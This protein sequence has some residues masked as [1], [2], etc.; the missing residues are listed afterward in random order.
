MS[1]RRL[2]V[3]PYRPSANQPGRIARLPYSS[4]SDFSRVR[5]AV[6]LGAAALTVALHGVLI[7]PLLWGTGAVDPKRNLFGEGDSAD[8]QA[9]DGSRMQVVLLDAAQA[10]AEDSSNIRTLSLADPLVPLREAPKI[11]EPKFFRSDDPPAL[12]ASQLSANVNASGGADGAELFGRY[13]GQITARIDRAWRRPRGSLAREIFSCRVRI[14]QDS[15][16]NVTVVTPEQCNPEVPWQRSL[17][18]AI[19]TASPLPAPPDQKVFARVVHLS[20]R[21]RPYTAA[22]PTDEYEPVARSAHPEEAPSAPSESARN[23]FS[24]LRYAPGHVVSLLITGSRTSVQVEGAS[25]SSH[26]GSPISVAPAPQP[27]RDDTEG[28]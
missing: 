25:G 1:S 21:A 18:E 2:E 6:R 9:E 13:M 15:A 16:G 3:A 28:H 19:W 14:E 24:A 20:F 4:R 8:E 11:P 22:M 17:I 23:V 12:D 10:S 27:S 26:A 5:L 7:T